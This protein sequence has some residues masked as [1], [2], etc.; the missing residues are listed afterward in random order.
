MTLVMSIPV[1]TTTQD[2]A[3]TIESIGAKLRAPPNNSFEDLTI[4]WRFK[5][6]LRNEPILLH[7]SDLFYYNTTQG[8]KYE[9]F[10]YLKFRDFEWSKDKYRQSITFFDDLS[11]L[12]LN[13]NPWIWHHVC[14]S[15]ESKSATYRSVNN[16]QLVLNKV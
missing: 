7:S 14:F 15:Y 2:S 6:Y 13:W 4:C 12:D 11:I 16:G 1:I 5:T 8:K 9:W 10:T 3:S